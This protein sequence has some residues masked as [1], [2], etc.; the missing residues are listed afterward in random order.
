MYLYFTW[1]H[2]GHV[3]EQNNESAAMFVYK[4]NPVGIGLFSQVKTFFY[5]KQF[6]KLLLFFNRHIGDYL[7]EI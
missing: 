4:R 3:C 2:D 7:A 1:R 5:S 6:A